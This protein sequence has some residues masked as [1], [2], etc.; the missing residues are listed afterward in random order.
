MGL[1]RA[2]PLS[3]YTNAHHLEHFIHRELDASEQYVTKDEGA[4]AS[5][6]TSPDTFSLPYI[7][8]SIRRAIISAELHILLN[9]FKRASY[10]GLESLSEARC[11]QVLDMYI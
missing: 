8:D 10:E 5:V 1:G 11:D 3:N 6:E 4:E 7:S 9:Y 2:L